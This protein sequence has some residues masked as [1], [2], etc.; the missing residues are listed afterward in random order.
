MFRMLILA[1]LYI[2]TQ[3]R[4]RI[5]D[6]DDP[7]PLYSPEHLKGASPNPALQAMGRRERLRYEWAQR[8]YW[9]EDV[10]DQFCK[11]HD[12]CNMTSSP[13]NCSFAQMERV[14]KT[15]FIY[16]AGKTRSL[17]PTAPYSFQVVPGD[18][19]KVIFFFQ[20][21]GTC[22]NEYTTNKKSL[23]GQQPR[24]L[25]VRDGIFARD[26][27]E[28][29]FANHTIVHVLYASGDY[30][31][32]NAE[33]KYQRRHPVTREKQGKAQH[34]GVENARAALEWLKYDSVL[35]GEKPLKELLVFG[36]SAGALGAQFWAH[37]VLDAIQAERKAV[38][39]DSFFGIFAHQQDLNQFYQTENI[40]NGGLLHWNKKLRAKCNAGQ[41][42]IEHMF[43]ATIQNHPQTV[44]TS[45]SPKTDVMQWLA[46]ISFG[47][48]DK[49]RRRYPL[50][51]PTLYRRMLQM[52]RRYSRYGNF[53]AYFVNGIGHCFS[54]TWFLYRASTHGNWGFS[55]RKDGI[56]VLDW[57]AKLPLQIGESLPAQCAGK[58]IDITRKHSHLWP[59][60]K[61]CDVMT[62]RALV[63]RTRNDPI[64]QG[65]NNILSQP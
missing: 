5:I 62:N 35:Q 2:Y 22:Y 48:W 39:I 56:P 38:L 8:M 30:H 37:H 64:T 51:F 46:Y 14:T 58:S 42:K 6:R 7:E 4:P 65:I 15:T 57:I 40:C 63:V 33:M 36:C 29:P 19:D 21:G 59:T 52:T 34:R 60:R 20:G 47:D 12:C 49:K 53:A 31:V 11:F 1:L 24:I 50:R 26:N 18:A 55:K 16:P 61:R 3:G 25:N 45:I 13:T 43:E 27:I 54:N 28:N 10:K 17:D 44:F 9:K 23:C 41:M 32:G